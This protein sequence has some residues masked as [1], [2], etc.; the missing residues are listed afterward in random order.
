MVVH[1]KEI[2][3]KLSN[4]IVSNSYDNSRCKDLLM[5]D[6]EQD[7]INVMREGLKRYGFNVYGFI[8]PLLALDFFKT[9]AGYCDLAISDLRMP[10]MNGFEFIKNVKR[11][12]PEIKVLLMTAFEYAIVQNRQ[13]YRKTCIN[14]GVKYHNTESDGSPAV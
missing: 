8:D 4:T 2:S 11:I 13:T 14:Q 9:S 6:D 10:K 7:L 5:L 1:T 3:A 12:K